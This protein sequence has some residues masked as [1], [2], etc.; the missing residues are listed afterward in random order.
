MLPALW[1]FLL[2]HIQ[3]EDEGRQY[4]LLP[5]DFALSQD[6]AGE[7]DPVFEDVLGQSYPLETVDFE[8]SS[9]IREK[10]A[11]DCSTEGHNLPPTAFQLSLT[12]FVSIYAIISAFIEDKRGRSGC[13]CRI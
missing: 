8:N 4:L 1:Q 7:Q 12:L 9:E 10:L 6:E 3:V 13:N 5:C 2:H 11:C